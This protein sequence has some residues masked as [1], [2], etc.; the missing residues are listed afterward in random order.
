[1]RTGTPPSVARPVVR[2][3]PPCSTTACG[4]LSRG[5]ATWHRHNRH[6]RQRTSDIPPEQRAQSLLGTMGADRIIVRPS[7]RDPRLVGVRDLREL[8]DEGPTH[9]RTG[10]S[11]K[12]CTAWILQGSHVGPCPY[13]T[14][15]TFRVLACHRQRF[16]R[17]V[18][19][20]RVVAGVL[21]VS[22][23]AGAGK[24]CPKETISAVRNAF[25]RCLLHELIGHAHPLGESDD[26]RL[27]ARGPLAT[28]WIESR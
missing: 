5:S 6:R 3:A 13:C 8:R 15:T 21:V 2:A 24:R 18:C 16:C 17:G 1:M 26:G 27:P 10:C 28:G 7:S 19:R 14:R 12:M 22:L 25:S 23:V 20:N 4:D 11:V 9:P